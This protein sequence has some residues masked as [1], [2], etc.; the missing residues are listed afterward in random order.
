VRSS[1]LE[2]QGEGM[3][4]TS[5]NH[6][7][8]YMPVSKTKLGQ[9]HIRVSHPSRSLLL[10]SQTMAQLTG[11]ARAF[12][13]P[14]HGSRKGSR[15]AADLACSVR[16]ESSSCNE[17]SPRLERTLYTREVHLSEDFVVF[18]DPVVACFD[19][20]CFKS[21]RSPSRGRGLSARHMQ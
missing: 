6:H 14:R 8:K 12:A 2:I 13:T 1:L 11:V 9:C 20:P 16:D 4:D 21:R 7:P 3:L 10:F 5:T 17:T 15:N 19:V 18:G